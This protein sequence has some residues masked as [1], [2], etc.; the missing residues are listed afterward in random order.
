[1][2][3]A[4]GAQRVAAPCHCVFVPQAKALCDVFTAE[5]GLEAYVRVLRSCL[6][7]PKAELASRFGTL[8]NLAKLMIPV[9]GFGTFTPLVVV[10]RRSLACFA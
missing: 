7:C 10:D 5:G 4:L 9:V 6:A 2:E 3:T 8:G 1:M